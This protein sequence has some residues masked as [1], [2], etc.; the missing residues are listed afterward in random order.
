M[1]TGGWQS[2]APFLAAF[3]TVVLAVVAGIQL[4]SMRR[5]RFADIYLQ[6]DRILRDVRNDRHQLYDLPQ[7]YAHWTESSKRHAETVLVPYE[8]V[9][10]LIRRKLISWRVVMD[11]RGKTFVDV[12]DHVEEH[13]HWRRKHTGSKRLAVH[14]EKVVQQFRKHL[15][16]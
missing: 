14:F 1:L 6:V 10:F 15:A 8:L 5:H 16:G 13:V 12:W 9:S 3:A 4:A 2:Y 11:A 7:E